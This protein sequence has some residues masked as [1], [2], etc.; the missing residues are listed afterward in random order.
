MYPALENLAP[1]KL[2]NDPASL[3]RKDASLQ[4][5]FNIA[6]PHPSSAKVSSYPLEKAGIFRFPQK[7]SNLSSSNG[8]AYVTKRWYYSIVC[9]LCVELLRVDCRGRFSTP[10][11]VLQVGGRS[12]TGCDWWK[13][14][15]CHDGE[16]HPLA[17]S[18]N[19]A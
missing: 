8:S 12:W 13:R 9:C 1:T 14:N 10:V 17:A 4:F 19:S 15:T 16:H 3:L 5:C 2:E 7:S 18:T 6:L 11:F